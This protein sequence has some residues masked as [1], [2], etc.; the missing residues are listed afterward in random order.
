MKGRIEYID[1]T[2]G[3][4]I[5]LVLIGHCSLP[6]VGKF[7]YMFHMPLFYILSGVLW[8]D[9]LIIP[10]VIDTVWGGVKYR[11]IK[12]LQKENVVHCY[13]HI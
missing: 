7:I 6:L 10:E 13:C 5:L 11:R 3:I 4:G 1:Q 12:S 2:K 9:D 8:K